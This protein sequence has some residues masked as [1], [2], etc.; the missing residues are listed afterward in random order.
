[1]HGFLERLGT[2]SSCTP[3][4]TSHT[5]PH[6]QLW[7]TLIMSVVGTIESACNQAVLQTTMLPFYSLTARNFLNK[8]TSKL[9]FG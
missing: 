3:S 1:M 5:L 4:C 6:T 9:I 2:E 7:N 8:E